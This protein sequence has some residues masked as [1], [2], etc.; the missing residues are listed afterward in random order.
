MA[1]HERGPTVVGAG[2]SSDFAH[3]VFCGDRM[4]RWNPADGQ[5][6]WQ[7]QAKGSA[8]GANVYDRAR[9]RPRPG[10]GADGDAT[11][12]ASAS[13]PREGWGETTT[14]G[15]EGLNAADTLRASASAATLHAD[16]SLRC[17]HAEGRG[18]TAARPG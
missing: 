15:R 14:T 2:P 1:R 5:A 12:R 4:R 7:Q 6:S 16:Q 3:R 9:V 11:L 17:G 10:G 13:A 8:S 18:A